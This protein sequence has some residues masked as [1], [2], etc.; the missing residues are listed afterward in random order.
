M[1][2]IKIYSN[3]SFEEFDNK[4]RLSLNGKML[5]NNSMSLISFNID[6]DSNINV[7]KRLEEEIGLHYFGYIQ[8]ME[9]VLSYI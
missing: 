4:F 5:E 2:Y 6:N 8:F 7:E 3:F 9:Y 1:K